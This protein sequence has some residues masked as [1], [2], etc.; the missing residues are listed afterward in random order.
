MEYKNKEWLT[1][2]Y[3]VEKLNIRQ[4]SEF[5]GIPQRTIHSWLV[6]FNIPRRA[7]GVEHWSDEQKEF[8]SQWNKNHPE[9][10]TGMKGKKHSEKTRLKMSISRKG[11]K[12]GNW[13]N[14]ITSIIRKL[15]RT[16]EYNKWRKAVFERDNY[17]C[18]ICGKKE[19]LQAHHIK[20]V[21]EYQDFIFDI[22]NGLTLCENCHV[23]L[24]RNNGKDIDRVAQK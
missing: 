12:N 14:G 1:Q 9:I 19:N 24:G 6:K 16:T 10:I 22:D 8:R 13:K 23:N 4:I 18:Q 5:T 3:I 21:F 20:S 15:R 7:V 11:N 17:T 2:K